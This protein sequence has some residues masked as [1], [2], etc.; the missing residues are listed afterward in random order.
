MKNKLIKILEIG[1]ER[2]WDRYGKD[3]TFDEILPKLI[4]FKEDEADIAEKAQDFMQ[5]LWI[6]D[7]FVPGVL[8][9]KEF[10]KAIWNDRG[11]KGDLPTWQYHLQQAVIS[12]NIIQYYLDNL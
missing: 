9:S 7:N 12:D 2:G 6:K 10:A 3:F 5:W 11:I 8:L 4:P 1:I